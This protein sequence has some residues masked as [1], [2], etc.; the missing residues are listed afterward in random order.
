MRRFTILKI[1]LLGCFSL[2]INSGVYAQD[3][4]EHTWLNQEKSAK[5]QI[6]K[7][8][9][10]KF[11]GKIIWLKEPTK[12]GKAKT[13]TKNVDPKKRNQPILGL[14]I[15]KGFV[16]DGDTEYEDGTIYDPKNGKTYD[17]K[18]KYK[19]NE[20]DIR[21]YIGISLIGRTTTWVKAE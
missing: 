16:K 20:L 14:L 9:D 10:S 21:G 15:L 2:L 6:Y 18:I 19:G 7:A 3:Q 12:D 11:Y 13:D 8:K 5:I 4:I 1:L 17:S